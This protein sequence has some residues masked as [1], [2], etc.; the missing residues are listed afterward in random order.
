MGLSCR[1]PDCCMHKAPDSSH[2]PL[3][4]KTLLSSLEYLQSSHSRKDVQSI[5]FPPFSILQENYSQC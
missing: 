2:K 3:E 5:L 1:V 4:T